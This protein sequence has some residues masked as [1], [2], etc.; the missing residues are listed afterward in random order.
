[1]VSV[2]VLVLVAGRGLSAQELSNQELQT[3]LHQSL[4]AN[5]P[6]RTRQL[7]TQVLERAD[8]GLEMLLAIGED[9]V[10]RDQFNM[11]AQVFA[12]AVTSYPKSFDA[13]YSL[14]LA[15]FALRRFTEAQ[16][17]LHSAVPTSADQRLGR[18]YLQ[19]KVDDALGQTE[20]AE[21]N[22]SAAFQ[23]APQQE[24]YALD[25]GLH[26]LRRHLYA[27]AMG[28]VQAGQK[29][30]P[31]SIYLDLELGLIQTLGDDRS[32]AIATCRRIL[33]KQPD[34]GPARF[35]LVIAY[36][37]NGENQD[38]LT[39][40]SAALRETD[41]APYLFYLHA[42]T[43][44]KLNSKD[45]AVMLHDLEEANRNVPACTFCYF[46]LSKVHQEMGDEDAAVRDLETLV[47]HVDPN[48]AQAWYRLSKMYQ[49]RGRSGDASK[50]LERFRRIQS[51]QDDEE[52]DY[53]RKLVLSTIGPQ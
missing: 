41:P 17:T 29:Y 37:L 45:Y 38:C 52:A 22:L 6:E 46:T 36:Y 14:A 53:L 1:M 42:A 7:L 10:D 48:F 50:A 43:L 18:E 30:H 3:A 25:L 9:L 40:T 33:S 16:A 19:G 31:D 20:L 28:T 47:T 13:R 24:N 44:L 12:R 8:A 34:F 2:M 23:G 21:T 49:R 15:D 35:L 27:K 51:K 26:Y 4:A 11:A 39:E 5:Q 32:R